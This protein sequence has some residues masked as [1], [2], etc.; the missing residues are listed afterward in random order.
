MGELVSG[1]PSAEVAERWIVSTVSVLTQLPAPV[2][3]TPPTH[4]TKMGGV[5]RR[6][7]PVRSIPVGFKKLWLA[8]TVMSNP[9]RPDE[10]LITIATR[11]FAGS[12]VDELSRGGADGQFVFPFFVMQ[13]WP[14]NAEW[15]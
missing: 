5:P 13:T 3:W 4:S 11:I 10:A 15:A 2:M 7:E 14:T 1:E 6:T 8:K 12:V 9:S